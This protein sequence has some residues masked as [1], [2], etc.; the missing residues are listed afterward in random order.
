MSK[1]TLIAVVLVL[2]AL[3][4]GFYLFQ[5]ITAENAPI[6]RVE[7]DLQLQDVKG[8]TLIFWDTHSGLS[9]SGN[10]YAEIRLTNDAVAKQ[11]STSDNWKALPP[12]E[13]MQIFLYGLTKDGKQEG[14]VFCDDYHN[15][16]FPEVSKGYYFFVDRSPE[17]SESKDVTR[18][19]NASFALYD[20]EAN[21]LY[22]GELDV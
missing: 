12:D 1:K 11:V 13:S 15:A 2:V 16:I 7:S 3:A 21:K 4:G 14:P 19:T 20:S 6:E 17:K 10:M 22:Y 8:K 9:G 5:Q 18:V